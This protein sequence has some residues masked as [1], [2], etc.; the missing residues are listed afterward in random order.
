VILGKSR[1]KKMHAIIIAAHG[2]RSESANREVREIADQL[3]A[4]IHA[5]TICAAFME[6]GSPSIAQAID[7]AVQA[8]ADA[9]SVFPYF[10]CAGMHITQDIPQLLEKCQQRHPQ[11]PI[12]QLDYFGRSTAAIVALIATKLT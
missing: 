8:G 10:L 2:S 9:I 3:R 5:D 11:V 4:S 6:F 7:E 12:R 1:R